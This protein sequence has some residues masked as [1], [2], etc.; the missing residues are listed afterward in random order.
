MLHVFI[1][2]V[3]GAEVAEMPVECGAALFY[4]GGDAGHDYVAA[5]ARVARDGE[6]PGG[7]GCGGLRESRGEENAERCKHHETRSDHRSASH[8]FSVPTP[9]VASDKRL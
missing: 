2:I 5:I 1:E 3:D 6:A 9:S 7:I 4:G 8:C